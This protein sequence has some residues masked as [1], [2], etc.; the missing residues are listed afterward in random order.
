MNDPRVLRRALEI[1]T[2]QSPTLR[3]PPS[4]PKAETAMVLRC[5]SLAHSF[6]QL[7]PSYRSLSRTGCLTSFT[8]GGCCICRDPKKLPPQLWVCFFLGALRNLTL[9]KLPF[10]VGCGE[11]DGCLC[12]ARGAFSQY[13]SMHLAA[14]ASYLKEVAVLLSMHNTNWLPLPDAGIPCITAGIPQ[15][16]SAG[17]DRN[18]SL[19]VIAA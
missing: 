16:A 1:M 9:R 13:V 12:C 14:A 4:P 3:P 15:A 2:A 17:Y 19:D 10:L 5:S 18:T 6:E 11:Q 7:P 8:M